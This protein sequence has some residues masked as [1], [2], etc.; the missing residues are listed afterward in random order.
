MAERIQLSRKKG[1][2]MP[3]N[4]VKVDRSSV[5]GNPFPIVGKGDSWRLVIENVEW[6]F[7]NKRDAA[8]AAVSAF[9]SWLYGF[10]EYRH[11]LPERRENLLWALTAERRDMACWCSLDMPCH[12]DVLLRYTPAHSPIFQKNISNEDQR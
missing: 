6:N 3:P 2:R 8:A 5:Y 9:E 1:W 10:G 4:T 7:N 12:A 11:L